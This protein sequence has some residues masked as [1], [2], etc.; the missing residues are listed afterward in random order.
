VVGLS[1]RARADDGE[2]PVEEAEKAVA[3]ASRVYRLLGAADAIGH[4]ESVTGHGYQEDK[5]RRLYAAVERWLRPPAPRGDA[6]LPA[7]VEPLGQMRCGLPEGDL[8]FRDVY[9]DAL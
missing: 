5:R 6:E 8:T 4:A 3:W 9:A 1:S 2:F 7:A